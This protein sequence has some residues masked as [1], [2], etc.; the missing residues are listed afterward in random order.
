MTI[1]RYEL[2]IPLEWDLGD[3]QVSAT[4]SYATYAQN[5]KLAVNIGN[6]FIQDNREEISRSVSDLIAEKI[7]D[8][9]W[10]SCE[11]TGDIDVEEVSEFSSSSLKSEEI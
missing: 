7:V 11:L 3:E 5:E 9:G 4:I 6:L 8:D 10:Q 2:T 1:K